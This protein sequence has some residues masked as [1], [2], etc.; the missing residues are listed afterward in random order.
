MSQAGRRRFLASLAATPLVPA[1]WTQ[2]A[3]APPLASPP[4]PSPPAP[5]PSPDP[6][7]DALAEAAR[8]RFGAHF[9]PGDFE[10]VKKAIAG[11]LQAAARLQKAVKLANSDEPVT[12]F[13]ARPPR[14]RPGT[15]PAAP[16]PRPRRSGTRRRG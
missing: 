8:Q 12:I 2:T 1:A 7:A 6:V 11:N 15:A 14:P 10:E 16:P 4:P 9:G 5:S 3:P 13:E